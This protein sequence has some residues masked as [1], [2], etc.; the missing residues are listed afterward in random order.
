MAD[1]SCPGRTSSQGHGNDCQRA[2]PSPAA[3]SNLQAACPD[4][5]SALSI[6]WL[7]GFSS[8]QLLS[9]KLKPANLERDR[10]N[11]KVGTTATG[12]CKTAPE[13]VLVLDREGYFLLSYRN[14]SVL[15]S[16]L[17]H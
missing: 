14:K 10:C 2:E 15:L 4:A 1:L 9:E 3:E 5:P 11:M 16:L 7:P 12:K 8:T 13:I 17:M 6:T